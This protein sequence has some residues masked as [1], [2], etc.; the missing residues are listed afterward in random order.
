MQIRTTARHFDL[1][2]DLKDHA[3]KQVAKLSRYFN[4]I[5]DSHLIMEMQKS[6]MTAELKIK[7]YGTVL[8]SKHRSFDMYDSVERVIGKMEVQLK[9]YKERLQ[10]KKAKTAQKASPLK[11]GGEAASTEEESEQM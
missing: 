4:H 1:T 10:D 11:R 7:V 5:I 8:T 3:E 9:R 2:D 6:R